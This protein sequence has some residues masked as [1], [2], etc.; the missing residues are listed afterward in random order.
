[1]LTVYTKPVCPQCDMLKRHLTREGIPFELVDVTAD[2]A[3]FNTLM[4]RGFK[5]VPVVQYDQKYATGAFLGDPKL[6][7]IIKQVREE[8]DLQPSTP[9]M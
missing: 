2:Q 8:I 9:S 4:A 5:T 6:R 7:E 1:M 3:A